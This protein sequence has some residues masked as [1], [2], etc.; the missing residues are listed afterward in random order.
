MLVKNLAILIN[1]HSDSSF[2]HSQFLGYF[3]FYLSLR[4]N[5]TKLISKRFLWPLFIAWPVYTFVYTI[6]W[7]WNSSFF[8]IKE[9]F[10]DFVVQ[11]NF[12]A[13]KR[14]LE[15]PSPP[16][17]QSYTFRL[18]PPLPLCVYVLCR[19]P[20]LGNIVQQVCVHCNVFKNKQNR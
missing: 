5:F 4:L 18:I 6:I 10:W 2:R 16:Y 12:F 20:R 15:P 14:K 8:T 3:H 11:K 19:W 9:K 1:F 7:Q 13:D 17:T